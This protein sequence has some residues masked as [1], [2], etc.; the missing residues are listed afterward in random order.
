MFF[1]ESGS[2]EPVQRMVMLGHLVLLVLHLGFV[3][4]PEGPGIQ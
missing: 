4:N 2:S 1:P 3:A